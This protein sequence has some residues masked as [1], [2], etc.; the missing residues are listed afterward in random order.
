MCPE[1]PDKAKLD[2]LRQAIEKGFAGDFKD[3]DI[4][5]IKQQI[6]SNESRVP[7][8]EE[9]RKRLEELVGDIDVDLNA[10]LTPDDD[11]SDIS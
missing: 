9:W 6:H 5:K 11:D 1:H 4:D 10:P 7:L 8:T 3:F 2:A